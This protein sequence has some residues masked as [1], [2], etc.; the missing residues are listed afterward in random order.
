MKKRIYVGAGA[1][2]V[3]AIVAAVC[4]VA[5]ARFEL[6]CFTD[7]ARRGDQELRYLSRRGW[8]IVIAI[9]IPLDGI[10]YLYSGRSR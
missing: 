2:A 10:F 9:V 8:T 6:L 4:I 5:V 3:I 7:L 1:S